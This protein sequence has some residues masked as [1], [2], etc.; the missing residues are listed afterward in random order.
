[1]P[2][3]KSLVATRIPVFD[4]ELFIGGR[5]ENNKELAVFPPTASLSLS[6]IQNVKCHGLIARL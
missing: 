3:R 1:M 5:R 6:A 2:E 4:F